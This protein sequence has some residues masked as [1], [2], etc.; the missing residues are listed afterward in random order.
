MTFSVIHPTARL[1]GPS[2]WGRVCGL[3][4]EAATSN[5][6]YVV[7]V[8][9][10]RSYSSEE[11]PEST[12]RAKMVRSHGRDCV[13]DNGN[14]AAAASTGDIIVGGTDDLYP[15][16]HWDQVLFSQIV[17][18]FGSLWKDQEY[19]I[20]LLPGRFTHCAMSRKLYERWSYFLCPEYVSMFADDDQYE[21]AIAEGVAVIQGADFGFEHRHHSTGGRLMDAVDESHASREAY[22]V[23][24]AVL[25]RRRREWST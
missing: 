13:V 19:L 14:A 20:S 9:S 25:E 4:I 21:R 3:W 12:H 6:E 1:G 15:P 22:D 5:F 2:S 11:W 23:G 10:G 16:D 17:D 8:W 18:S 24:R 7:S